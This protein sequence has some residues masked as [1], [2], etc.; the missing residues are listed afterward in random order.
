M[1]CVDRR[2]SHWAGPCHSPF[3]LVASATQPS[4]E[5]P[6][7]DDD[8]ERPSRLL[9]SRP[10]QHS[11]SGRSTAPPGSPNNTNGR[12]RCASPG[13]PDGCCHE[14]C[15]GPKRLPPS[16]R[17]QCEK[18]KSRKAP[19][20][21]AFQCAEEDS[22]LHPVSLD[23]ALNLVTRVSYPSRSCRSVQIV[24]SRGRYGR[25]GRSGCCHGCCHGRVVSWSSIPSSG[26]GEHAAWRPAVRRR[27]S[28]RR[29]SRRSPA[30][31]LRIDPGRR[32]RRVVSS[33][34]RVP[35]SPS[36]SY[37]QHSRRPGPPRTGY[38]TTRLGRSRRERKPATAVT[39]FEDR[40]VRGARDS[41]GRL[42]RL[43]GCELPGADRGDRT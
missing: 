15:H 24:R 34:T 38:R 16:G 30:S 5:T 6:A 32:A 11:A 12:S 14:R 13:L 4:T 40:S 26:D 10:N 17:S 2:S 35:T 22:N 21:R 7:A 8:Q 18:P 37:V 42:P 3:R 1:P 39:G 9:P 43:P 19:L 31:P 27:P 20:C 33:S 23:Q 41:S 36:R 28:P 29:R 25:I